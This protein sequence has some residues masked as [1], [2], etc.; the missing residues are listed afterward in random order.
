VHA[1]IFAPFAYKIFH[2]LEAKA[3]TQLSQQA[4]DGASLWDTPLVVGSR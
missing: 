4:V 2:C 1:D 3:V